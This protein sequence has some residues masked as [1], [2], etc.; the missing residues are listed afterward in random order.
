M[1]NLLVYSLPSF[2]LQHNKELI[3]RE[4]IFDSY[5]LSSNRRGPFLLDFFCFF[6]VLVAACLVL[7]IPI[8]VKKT[9]MTL[10]QKVGK[11]VGRIQDEN[12]F[13]SH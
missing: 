4:H 8:L 9:A 6:S 13:R 5:L 12:Q 7:C 10:H 11:V 3:M 1:Q 2:N